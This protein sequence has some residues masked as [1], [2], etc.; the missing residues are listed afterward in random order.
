MTS[1]EPTRTLSK[2]S[3][4]RSE[5]RTEYATK[6]FVDSSLTT[7]EAKYS[8]PIKEALGFLKQGRVDSISLNKERPYAN[9][10][11]IRIGGRIM[12]SIREDSRDIELEIKIP[13]LVQRLKP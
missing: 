1:M 2:L 9:F 12:V 10:H 4:K 6:E 11:A 8:L 5:R 3:I 7:F 13:D